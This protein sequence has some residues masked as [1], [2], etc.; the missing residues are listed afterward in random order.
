MINFYKQWP[1][2][3]GP[4]SHM[5]RCIADPPGVHQDPRPGDMEGPF[6]FWFDGGAG[7]GITG[8]GW[9]YAFQNGGEAWVGGGFGA[10]FTANVVC[11]NGMRLRI[12]EE[13]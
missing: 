9:R 1:E 12:E 8:G 5:L 7:I 2:V 3:L 6:E 11:P 10:P 13:R 4:L